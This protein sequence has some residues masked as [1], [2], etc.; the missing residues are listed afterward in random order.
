MIIVGFAKNVF[1][2]CP[3]CGET[4]RLDLSDLKTRFK[5]DKEFCRICYTHG[6][7]EKKPHTLIID[8]DRNF[9][10]RALA[11]ADRTYSKIG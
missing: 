4:V 7:F 1:V 6:I 11:V 3:K 8:I 10:P 2:N 9:D 5:D